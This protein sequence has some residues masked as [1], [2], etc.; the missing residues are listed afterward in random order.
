MKYTVAFDTGSSD[1]FLPSVD[2][3]SS[4]S[5]H[6][7]YDPSSS[8]NSQDLGVSFEIH[9]VNG[10]S[11]SGEEYS[12]VVQIAGLTVCRNT[13]PS[14][15]PFTLTCR[16]KANN[17]TLGLATNYS[18]NLQSSQF[19]ADGLMGLAFES[20]SAYNATPVFQTLISQNVLTSPVFGL[21]L[22][23][24]GSELF[25]GGTNDTLFTGNFTWVPLTNQV[26]NDM[27]ALLK[28]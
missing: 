5:G 18:T 9:L 1:L 12:D 14:S 20:I 2:C 16:T 17:Q 23:T 22:A 27:K 19:P 21:K 26:C 6:K 4:C 8:A 25:L 7:T 10:A 15:R 13:P 28:R 24:S 3:G 11:V